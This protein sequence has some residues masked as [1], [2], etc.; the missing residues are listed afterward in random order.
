MLSDEVGFY[1]AAVRDWQFGDADR[2]AASLV[3]NRRYRPLCTV[4]AMT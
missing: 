2:I 4:M 3:P 1:E